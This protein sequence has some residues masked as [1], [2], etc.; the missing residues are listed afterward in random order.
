MLR[1]ITFR[2]FKYIMKSNIYVEYQG[3]QANTTDFVAAAKKIWQAKGN[4]VKDL[5]TLDLYAK[6]EENMVYCVF[7]GEDSDSFPMSE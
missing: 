1:L 6:P 4:K 3:V 2:R 7:N 5:K